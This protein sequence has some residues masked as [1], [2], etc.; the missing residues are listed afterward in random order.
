MLSNHRAITV[1]AHAKVNLTLDVLGKRPDGFHEVAMLMQAVELH[2]TLHISPIESG[3]ELT[4][5]RAG[6]PCDKTNL[7][8][9]AAELMCGEYGKSGVRIHLEKRI[10]IAA[11]L[12][13]GST[14]AAAVIKG[15]NALWE[16]ALPAERL[17]E[18]AACLGS[19]VPFC[20]WGGLAKAVGRGEILQPLPDSQNWGVVLVKP[21][22]EVSTA[23]VYGNFSGDRVKRRPDETR[24]LE[25]LSNKN[26]AGVSAELVN[27]LETVTIAKYP[28]LE[29]LKEKLLKAGAAGV[30]MSGSG[31][32]VFGV[33]P[34][35]QSA[36][37]VAGRLDLPLNI[38]VIA[39]E[40][41]KREAR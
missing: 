32:T 16:L 29:T 22:F 23:W 9:R 11:G 30:L 27:V 34:D 13:G 31:P 41:V 15:L 8:F 12:A 5:D 17:E 39:T 14:D 19:D 20:L 3:I 33:T 40:T 38:T 24:I 1:K 25:A 2:D 6:L 10:P 7:A 28:E 36:K 26:L 21:E 37:T 4:C 18:M 35:A